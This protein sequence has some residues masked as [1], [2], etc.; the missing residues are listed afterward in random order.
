[1]F[2]PFLPM[3]PVQILLN[4]LLYDISEMPIPKDEV[5]EEYLS[6]PRHWDMKFIRNFMLTVGTVSSF[7][8]FL[9]FYVM[10]VVFQAGESLF[11]TGWFVESIATQ[12]LVIFII[13]TRLNPLRSRPHPWLTVTSLTVVVLAAILPF[14]S[15]GDYFGFTPLPLAF[16]LVLAAM[17]L[18]YL[19][20]VE[21]MKRWFYRRF[22][23][24]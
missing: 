10:L 14:T 17:V 7:F 24:D 19:V 20:A 15:L 13:R 2:L 3:L 23:I 11:Q 8:D 4:N 21:A 5:D 16:F 9:T 18:A 6:R 1:M 22:A 12:V